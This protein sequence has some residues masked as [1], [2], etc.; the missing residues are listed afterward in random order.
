MIDITYSKRKS[1]E[2]LFEEG[3]TFKEINKEMKS[4]DYIEKELKDALEFHNK[5]LSKYIK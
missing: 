4:Y 2:K 3:K 1:F 5:L